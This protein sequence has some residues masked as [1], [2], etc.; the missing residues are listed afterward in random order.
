MYNKLRISGGKTKPS[1]YSGLPTPNSWELGAFYDEVRKLVG[2]AI[3]IRTPVISLD[4]TQL[5][6]SKNNVLDRWAD[7]FNTLLDVDRADVIQQQQ[8][9]K[10]VSIDKVP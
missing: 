3:R 8:N 5:L 7:H 9:Q 1:A 4:G 10:V 6:T 2:T